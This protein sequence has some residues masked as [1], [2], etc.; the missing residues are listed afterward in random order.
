MEKGKKITL[1]MLIAKAQQRK[2]AEKVYKEV[3]CDSLEGCLTLEKIP[4]DR[5]LAVY[6]S[7]EDGIV[8]NMAAN[9]EVIYMS[10]PMLRNESL[11]EEFRCAEPHDIVRKVLDDNMGDITRLVSAIQGFY[12]MGSGEGM[13][14]E[15]KN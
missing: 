13:V 10:C 11:F 1:D 5:I 12:G 8:A 3:W 9:V 14:E 4:L 15:V 2:T 7:S 6:D